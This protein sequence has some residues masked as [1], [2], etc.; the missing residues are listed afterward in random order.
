[1]KSLKQNVDIQLALGVYRRSMAAGWQR[2]TTA[3]VDWSGLVD[4]RTQGTSRTA[5]RTATAAHRTVQKVA[6][7]STS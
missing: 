7:T 1:M 6:C 2:W 3:R 5:L 4:T